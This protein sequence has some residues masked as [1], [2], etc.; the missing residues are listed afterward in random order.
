MFVAGLGFAEAAGATHLSGTVIRLVSPEGTLVV[1]V[2]DPDVSINIDGSDVVIT[3]AG[4]KEIRV[5]GTQVSG[6]GL[7]NFKECKNLAE[8]LLN[9]S[10]VDDAGLAGLKECK[11]LKSL[12]LQNTLDNMT[13]SDEGLARLKECKNL[14]QLVL[15]GNT[16]ITAKGIN[17]LQKA[18]PKYK[19]KWD[20]GVIEPK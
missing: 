19:F 6:E 13:L 17:Q 1:E 14:T 18:L 5:Q 11:N 8:L 12:A 20:G 2:D 3:G 15:I 9:G 16:K 7:A 4:P 10:L